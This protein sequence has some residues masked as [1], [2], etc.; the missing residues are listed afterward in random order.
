MIGS[1]AV[2]AVVLA[3]NPQA[4]APAPVPEAEQEEQAEAEAPALPELKL[5]TGE[6]TLGSNLAQLTVPEGFGYLSPKDAETLL[7]EIWGNPPAQGQSTLGMLVPKDVPPTSEESWGVVITYDDDGHVGDEDARD[8]NYTDLLKDMQAATAE[9]NKEREANGFPAVQLVGWA[10]PP[11]YDAQAKKL[12]WAKE[13][14]FGGGAENT[15]NYN[16]RV[17]GSEGVLVLNAVAAM[18]QLPQI[19]SEMKKLVTFV[20]FKSGHRYADFNPST[21]RMAT[22]GIAGLVAGKVAAKA[23]LF[24]ILLAAL[25]AGKKAVLAVILGLGALASRLFKGRGGGGGG[26][27]QSSP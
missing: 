26:G 2:L 10:E 9:S 1:V 25:V 14:Q 6:I 4:K 15:L 18:R 3:G 21:G 16:I 7:V 13:L 17:L 20:D 12:Y 8:I 23:G 27:G 19:Q 22:Y 11:H 5:Q 24:K